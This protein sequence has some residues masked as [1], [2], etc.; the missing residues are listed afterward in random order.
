M[1]DLMNLCGLGEGVDRSIVFGRPDSSGYNAVLPTYT[2]RRR[3]R[4][5][6]YGIHGLDGVG[7]DG[8][9]RP[10][11]P[12]GTVSTGSGFNP[13]TFTNWM[14][15]L[16]SSAGNVAQTIQQIQGKQPRPAPVVQQPSNMSK[17]LLYGGLAVLALTVGAK[18]LKKK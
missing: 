6:R 11:G 7:P 10:D 16:T 15:A 13:T 17:Y 18:M 8:V 4:A 1:D 5:R 12:T 3:S 9:F 14:N 2:P